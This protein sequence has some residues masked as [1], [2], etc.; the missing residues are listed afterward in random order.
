[1]GYIYGCYI[2]Y[3]I[4]LL[5]MVLYMVFTSM[6]GAKYPFGQKII[7][8]IIKRIFIFFIIIKGLCVYFE[9]TFLICTHTNLNH[10]PIL[11]NKPPKN[12]N[13]N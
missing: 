7:Q 12:M 3:Y 1:M 4:W 9:Q 10:M 11:R 8:V 2:W 6:W 5:R 13:F